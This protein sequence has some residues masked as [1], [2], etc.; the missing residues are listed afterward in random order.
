MLCT[1][2]TVKSKNTMAKI[3]RQ[4]QC[5]VGRPGK[6]QLSYVRESVD[7]RV[8]ASLHGILTFYSHQLMAQG[9]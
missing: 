6:N 7:V 8:K 4:R 2:S 9:H 1:L 5:P 3:K